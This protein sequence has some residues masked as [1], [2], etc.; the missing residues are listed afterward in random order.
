MVPDHA[1]NGITYDWTWDRMGCS[2][3]DFFINLVL[4]RWW[5]A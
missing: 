2:I 3:V 4:N 1:D 5:Y